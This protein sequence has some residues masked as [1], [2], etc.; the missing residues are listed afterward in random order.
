MWKKVLLAVSITFILAIGMELFY[1]LPNR[2]KL[3]YTTENVLEE[4]TV[5]KY[6]KDECLNEWKDY[7]ISVQEEIKVVNQNLN[8]ENRHYIIKE[9]NGFINVYYINEKK[10]EVLYKVTEIGTQYLS[11]EDVK[12]LKDGIEVVGLQSLNQILEDFE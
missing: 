4:K 5:S 8:D 3:D 1:K 7:A 9:E 6:I 12:K 2:K 10:E 11:D